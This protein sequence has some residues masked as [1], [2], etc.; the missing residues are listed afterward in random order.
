[1]NIRYRVNRS[2]AE[3]AELNALLSAGKHAAR[4]IKRG[5]ILLAADADISDDVIASSVSVGGSM[6]SRT[7]RCFVEG[8]LETGAQR[9]RAPRGGA[10]AVGQGGWALLIATAC[11]NLP[12]GRKR[13]TLDLL[14]G[15]M[16]RLT[17]HEKLSRETVRRR[18]R[19]RPQAV[20]QGYV[21]HSAAGRHLRRAD[22][23]RARSRCLG[24]RSHAPD[25]VLR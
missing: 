25:G 24:G 23:G 18:L 4:E 15:A 2:E 13:W 8:N 7:K 11:S 17:Q 3:R 14:A 9:G 1:M 12:Q 16:V 21:V 6:V 19:G 10:Q 20:A 5:Q 22:R